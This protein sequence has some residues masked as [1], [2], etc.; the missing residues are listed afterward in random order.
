MNLEAN[1]PQAREPNESFAEASTADSRAL[2]G[3]SQGRPRYAKTVLDL[4][5]SQLVAQ[6]APLEND[7]IVLLNDCEAYR[8]SLLRSALRMEPL[9]VLNQTVT[10]L[11]EV[12]AVAQKWV[13]PVTENQPLTR[14]LAA[15]GDLY[16]EIVVLRRQLDTSVWAVLRRLFRGANLS[17]A[18]RRAR[19]REVHRRFVQVL[20]QFFLLFQ[21]C[22][23]SPASGAAWASACDVFLRDL[24]PVLD[25]LKC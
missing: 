7:L 24:T 13:D 6:D 11:D 22:Y 20:R 17:P 19:F 2:A 5:P 3:G 12:V 16:G 23:R 10:I 15:A 4:L 25:R 18:E 14:A 9:E 21:K 8:T 1:G